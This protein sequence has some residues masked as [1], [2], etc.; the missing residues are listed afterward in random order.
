[1]KP[2]PTLLI[3]LLIALC[4]GS[5]CTAGYR[6]ASYNDTI[7]SP[8]GPVRLEATEKKMQLGA[9]LDFQYARALIYGELGSLHG[10]AIDERGRLDRLR[11]KRSGYWLGVDLPLLT[12]WNVAGG[13]CCTYPGLV[14]NRHAIELWASG[15]VQPA[16]TRFTADIGLV[17][18]FTR[19]IG[20]KLYGGI[21][22]VV[23]SANTN[24]LDGSRRFEDLSAIGPTFGFNIV[25]PAGPWGLEVIEELL[26]WDK[27]EREYHRGY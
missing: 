5:G 16:A 14:K 11:E 21:S 8:D 10:D 2:S 7:A 26:F 3:A 15:A 24:G 6:Y 13:G 19:V 17:Y 9:T 25:L 18:Y 22:T 23:F 27:Q 4:W 12:L 20:A 1:M